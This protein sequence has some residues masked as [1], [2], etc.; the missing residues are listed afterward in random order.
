MKNVVLIIGSE[1]QSNASGFIREF[2]NHNGVLSSV[3]C[4][5]RPKKGF[6]YLKYPLRYLKYLRPE[7]LKQIFTKIV[8]RLFNLQTIEKVKRGWNVA[9]ENSWDLLDK[10]I[11]IPEYAYTK[12]IPCYFFNSLTKA[13]LS[14]F[15]KKGPTVFV[16]YAGGILGED[17][18]SIPNSEFFNAHMGEMPRY[19]GMNVIEWAVLENKVPK[20]SVMTMTS[21]IDGGDVI[22]EK[23]ILINRVKSI[24]E[25][26]KIG[27][28][29][30]YKAMAEGI[31]KYSKGELQ[32]QRQAKNPRY[33]YKMHKQIRNL[34]ESKLI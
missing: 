20:V 7:F 19:R 17:I 18:L 12:K 33:Y 23:E 13:E 9:G 15:T 31:S 1:N 27:Y 3:I 25:L 14:L 5:Q 32:L 22:L 21:T 2:E 24:A 28:I 11:N 34:L 6:A 30:C 8:C 4:L 10:G 26:R 16:M 29:Y